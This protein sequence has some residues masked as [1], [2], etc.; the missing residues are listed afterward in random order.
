M[1]TTLC[2][3]RAARVRNDRGVAAVE[4]AFVVP[5]LVLFIFGIIEGGTR[6][7][8]QSQV[9]HY[10]FVAAR[11]VAIQ[12]TA[13]PA[14]IVDELNGSDSTSYAV[15][16]QYLPAGST[17]CSTAGAESVTVTVQATKTSATRMF[18]DYTLSGKGVARCEN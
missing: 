10:A 12:P 1:D 2:T 11:D 13:S 5:L 8:Q 16:V 15:S 17:S 4:F 6:Y 3:P 7:A 14:T 9:N 18:G